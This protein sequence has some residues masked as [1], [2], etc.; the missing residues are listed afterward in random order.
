[1]AATDLYGLAGQV[2][3][4]QFRVDR[5]IGEGG[6][7]V[8]YRGQ[9]V[10]LD[11]PVAI[12][13]L[14]LQTQLGSALVEAF[15]RRFRDESKIHYRLSRG[16][17]HIARTI[18]AGTTMAPATGALVPYMV[19]EWLEGYT[20][21]EELRARR[22]RGEKG[23]GIQDV[24]RLLDP[25][26]DAMAFAHSQGVVHR[27]LNPSNIFVSH[28]HGS[29]KLK[30][31]D[32][33][34]AKVISDHA[35]ALGPRAATIGQIRMFTPA[36]A[37]PEQFHD[38]LGPIGSHTD[39]YSFAVLVVELLADR[40][41]IEGEHIGEFADRA[42]DPERRPTPRA[43]GVVVGDAVEAVIA[44]AVTV[45]PS[46][47]PSDVGEFWGMLKNAANRDAQQNRA[48]G[49]LGFPRPPLA[50]A[51]SARGFQLPVPRTTAGGLPAIPEVHM[52]NPATPRQ[53]SPAAEPAATTSSGPPPALATTADAGRYYYSSRPPPPR[54]D[55]DTPP[56]QQVVEAMKALRGGL[57]DTAVNPN[58]TSNE[59]VQA[60][61]AN[62]AQG[63]PPRKATL[64]HG[65]LAGP[66]P[67]PG[68]YAAPLAQTTPAAVAL[69]PSENSLEN[70]AFAATVQTPTI[71]SQPPPAALVVAA[72]SPSGHR[73]GNTAASP[74]Q[75]PAPTP[76]PQHSF[77]QT[78]AWPP[79]STPSP[80]GALPAPA[81]L[82]AKD[83]QPP[84]SK[85]S[86]VQLLIAIALALT[87]AL[88]VVAIVANQLSH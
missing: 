65:S 2:L 3:D 40:T 67:T 12:K 74:V 70:A 11:E 79:A 14:K 68:P 27:D 18:A 8:V 25:V 54:W 51:P 34:V 48:G 72:T 33:G 66:A 20:L 5:A 61:R 35:L 10:G 29:P 69:A 56:P 64:L 9:H 17:L 32:F 75:T 80:G 53:V 6:F 39:V 71:A 23:R 59:P 82:S 22:Q 19:L 41:P 21:S 63:M 28:G 4:G 1:M 87:V 86:N 42:L 81:P 37:A 36:Y 38:A 60:K 84:T 13:C 78:P 45:D 15:I 7:S 83:A 58:A 52:P 26:A 44:R 76:A 24:L 50:A 57:A 30:V 85:K 73:L 49:E 46:Q 47:R 88:V 55:S 62:D 77:V 43:M 16:S 31:L